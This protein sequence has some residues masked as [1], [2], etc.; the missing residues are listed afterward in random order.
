MDLSWSWSP[1]TLW[2]AELHIHTHTPSQKCPHPHHL[3]LQVLHYVEKRGFANGMKVRDLK[4][5]SVSWIRNKYN[6][7]NPKSKELSLAK[8]RRIV[9]ED[10]SEKFKA[11]ERPT[12]LLQECRCSLGAER[13]SSGH[14]ARKW[15]LQSYS[16]K[17]LIL[18]KTW[19]N[20]EANPPPNPTDKSPGLLIPAH[21]L[22]SALWDP[23]QR[24]QPSPYR[25]LIY[26]NS[27]IV[28]LCCFEL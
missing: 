3:N 5:G 9:M 1:W 20:W 26:R 22:I 24:N 4:V 12:V 2:K 16:S 18:P 10:K 21:T 27:E 14:P 28:S 8:G 13:S 19:V 6:H 15:K 17:E 25:L 7:I 23:E 11:W